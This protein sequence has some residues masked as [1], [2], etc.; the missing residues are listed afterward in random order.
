MAEEMGKKMIKVLGKP[1]DSTHPRRLGLPWR[2]SLGT[3]PLLLEPLVSGRNLEMRGT[4]YS[5]QGLPGP[6]PT[7]TS[8]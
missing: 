8:P 7:L 2:E 3:V 5:Y 6:T 1:K 4:G